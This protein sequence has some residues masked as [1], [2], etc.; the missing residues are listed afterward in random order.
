MSEL[1]GRTTVLA[2]RMGRQLWAKQCEE[3]LAPLSTEAILRHQG[4]TL[5]KYAMVPMRI[6]SSNSFRFT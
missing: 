1:A 5:L 4:R 3:G 2:V 6:S